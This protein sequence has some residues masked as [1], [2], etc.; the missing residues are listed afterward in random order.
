VQI[1]LLK[2]Y[3][4]GDTDENVV[5]GIHLTINGL[6][7]GLRNSGYPGCDYFLA[8][9]R[10]TSRLCS[11][12]GELPVLDDE[13]YRQSISRGWKRCRGIRVG[14]PRRETQQSLPHS[15]KRRSMRR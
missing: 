12:H 4:A 10:R 1:E 5:T 3:R 7:A 13:R 2:R 9:S 8:A 6:A 11:L 15:A 14:L